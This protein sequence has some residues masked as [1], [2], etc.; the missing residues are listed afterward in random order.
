MVALCSAKGAPGVTTAALALALTW[1]RPVVL[2]EADPSGGSIL[3]GFLAPRASAAVAERNL[4]ATATALHAGDV[5]AIHKNLIDLDPPNAE[6]LL[7]LGL[8]DPVQVSAVEGVWAHLAAAWAQLRVGERAVDVIVDCGRLGPSSPWPVLA[9]A[10][11]VLLTLEPSRPSIAAA[12]A[13]ARRLEGTVT[14]P[15]RLTAMVIGPGEHSASEAVRALELEVAASLPWDWKAASALGGNGRLKPT[16]ALMRS[17]AA[18]AHRLT[19]QQPAAP[20]LTAGG[21]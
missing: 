12:W 3:A 15:G 19:Q 7:L 5:W 16:S 9:G 20:A 4:L 21:A 18:A 6:R 13:G 11:Q 14:G 10:D 8:S 17:A 1:P 2:V